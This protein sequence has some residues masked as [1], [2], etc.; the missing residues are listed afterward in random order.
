MGLSRLGMPD[1]GVLNLSW[2]AYPASSGTGTPGYYML[3]A[4]EGR[5]HPSSPVSIL[6]AEARPVM[7]PF[8]ET[9]SLL[10]KLACSMGLPEDL[11]VTYC[12]STALVFDATQARRS[13]IDLLF[14]CVYRTAR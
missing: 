9:F 3:N 5:H 6:V 8:Q 12:S 11:T 4:G 7:T 1:N 2:S 10:R 14:G 13:W